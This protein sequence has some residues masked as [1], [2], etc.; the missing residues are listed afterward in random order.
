VNLLH[1]EDSHIKG[2]PDDGWNHF[3]I[4]VSQTKHSSYA[5]MSLSGK[6]FVRSVMEGYIFDD[7]QS[8]MNYQIY[9]HGDRATAQ[10]EFESARF[11]YLYKEYKAAVSTYNNLFNQK[12]QPIDYKSLVD[13]LPANKN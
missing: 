4:A 11:Q 13:S 12:K 5:K 7:M 2:I 8:Y 1:H 9:V 10:K 6:E 3:K